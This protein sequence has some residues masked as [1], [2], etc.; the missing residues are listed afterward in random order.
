M[1]SS[2]CLVIRTINRVDFLK[3][4]IASVE[5]QTNKDFSVVAVNN[6]GNDLTQDILESWQQTSSLSIHVQRNRENSGEILFPD[7]LNCDY[8]VFVGDDDLLL[9]TAVAT[10]RD[11]M[12]SAPERSLYA[13]SSKTISKLGWR[14]P[15]TFR[16]CGYGLSRETVVGRLLMDS[17]FIFSATAYRTT[18]LQ[19]S[20]ID[21]AQLD[22]CVDWLMSLLCIVQGAPY[23]SEDPILLS[24]LHSSQDSSVSN[25]QIAE[26]QKRAMLI[27]FAASQTIHEYLSTL[28]QSEFAD[29]VSAMRRYMQSQRNVRDRD[30]SIL[31]LVQIVRSTKSHNSP[32]CTS[33]FPIALDAALTGQRT[34]QP[35]DLEVPTVTR[36]DGFREHLYLSLSMLRSRS[37]STLGRFVRNLLRTDGN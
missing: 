18:Y 13:F 35:V 9:P 17:C 33:D 30:A 19:R 21:F 27:N 16:P 31:A 23:I 37:R 3:Q 14:L 24:R 12:R 5:A 20:P 10:I 32:M 34:S 25:R 15:A 4:L 29:L 28:S 11:A 7:A 8:Q 36:Q 22:Y 2:L 6:G 1:S 26:E